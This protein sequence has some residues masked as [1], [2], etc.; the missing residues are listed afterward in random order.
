VERS[1]PLGRNSRSSDLSESGKGLCNWTKEMITS[2]GR[3]RRANR[4]KAIGF[5]Q[6][7]KKNKVREHFSIGE[8]TAAQSSITGCRIRALQTIP[9]RTAYTVTCELALVEASG[10]GSYACE[11]RESKWGEDLR[12]VFSG[13]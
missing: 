1:A 5:R 12:G 13:P 3:M 2:V 10:G 9:S 6:R 8:G 4:L 7:F 11:T